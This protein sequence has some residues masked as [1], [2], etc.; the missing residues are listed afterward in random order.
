[1][2]SLGSAERIADPRADTESRDTESAAPP[3]QAQRENG[4]AECGPFQR[5]FQGNFS[6]AAHGS[7]GSS[8]PG[9]PTFRSELTPWSS[10]S[11]QNTLLLM[12]R[13]ALPPGAVWLRGSTPEA[14]ANAGTGVAAVHGLQAGPE[15]LNG[16]TREGISQE[17]TVRRTK[18]K[19]TIRG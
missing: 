12:C 2:G 10:G 18:M 3:S 8:A 4:G 13:R 11:F 14:T 17:V 9:L 19:L 15:R 5:Q 6:A 1:M 7:S 16:H